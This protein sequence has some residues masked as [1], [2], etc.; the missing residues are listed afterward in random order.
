VS[1]AAPSAPRRSLAAQ[2]GILL[3]AVGG[4][5]LL[6]APIAIWLGGS[7]GLAAAGV[8]AGLCLAGAMGALLVGWLLRDLPNAAHG[9]L[10]GMLPRMG[11]PLGGAMVFHMQGGV[12]AEAGLL[13]YLVVFYPV[14]LGVE[15]F[16]S[17]PPT[18][19]AG[20]PGKTVPPGQTNSDPP[21]DA[22]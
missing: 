15:T 17:L 22:P 9:M 6:V 3:L 18:G 21:Q 11:I 12:L 13:V 7:I 5:F 20:L 2:T 1:K 16:L 14:A 8:A 10:A 4:E 19:P